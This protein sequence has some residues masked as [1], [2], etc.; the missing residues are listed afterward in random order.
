MKLWKADFINTRIEAI[1]TSCYF[2]E[3]LVLA[4]GVDEVGADRFCATI[5][6]IG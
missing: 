2:A 5:V 3:R 4:A 1:G 6:P